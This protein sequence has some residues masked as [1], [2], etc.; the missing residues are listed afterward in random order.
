VSRFRGSSAHRLYRRLRGTEASSSPSRAH[1][2]SLDRR[3]AKAIEEFEQVASEQPGQIWGNTKWLGV[4]AL[5][6]P[7][8]LWIAE[9]I[10]WE[11]RPELFIET[12]VYQGGSALFYAH[13]F[14]LIGSGEVLG[15]DIDLSA[16]HPDVRAHPR[17]TLIEGSSVEPAVVDRIREAAQEKRV[18]VNLDSDHSAAH[19]LEELLLLAPL[20]SPNCY[21]VVEDTAIGRPL[22]K[23]LLPGPAEALDEWL[24]LG[25][26][27]EVDL[28][29]EKFLLTGSPGGYLRRLEATP[30]PGTADHTEAAHS[31][32]GET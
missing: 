1:Q 30:S 18:M 4:P 28:S 24:A 31:G 9:E 17:I 11:T 13:M 16:V 22:G 26:P 32:T 8:D 29:R 14:D 7:W 10:L 6:G 25:Q 23:E 3:T 2:S 21:L 27:F 5:K 15:V 19:V 12:G 20:V